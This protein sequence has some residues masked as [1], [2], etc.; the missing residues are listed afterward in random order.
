MVVERQKSRGSTSPS[1]V[2]ANRERTTDFLLGEQ[3]FEQNSQASEVGLELLGRLEDDSRHAQ[4]PGGVSVGRDI[5]NIDGFF[6]TDFASFKRHAIDDGI[7]LASSHA[8]GIDPNRE[9]PEEGEARFLMRHM[10][11]IGVR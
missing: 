9:K 4:T 5:V 7:G 8:K 2:Y 1:K 10:D 3:L 6:G 11:R